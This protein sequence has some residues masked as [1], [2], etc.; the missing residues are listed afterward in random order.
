M[1]TLKDI[2]PILKTIGDFSVDLKFSDTFSDTAIYWIL[3]QSSDSLNTG[4]I[5]MTEP[6]RH[7]KY[8][9][10]ES[11]DPILK[12]IGESIGIKTIRLP[13]S[14]SVLK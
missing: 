11:I 1:N 4:S 12:S 7:S 13:Q 5:L 2:G 6:N 8:R 3:T 10:F 9:Y 14:L